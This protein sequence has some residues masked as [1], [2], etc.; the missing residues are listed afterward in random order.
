MN[1]IFSLVDIVCDF[2]CYNCKNLYK[3]CEFPICVEVMGANDLL[4]WNGSSLEFEDENV[5]NFLCVL[6]P[7]WHVIL[8]LGGFMVTTSEYDI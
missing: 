6:W 7:L 3:L 4:L 8:L 5:P 1:N 2:W